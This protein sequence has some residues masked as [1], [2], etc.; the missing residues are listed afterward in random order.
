MNVK[1]F[2]ETA[3]PFCGQVRLGGGDCDC[4]GAKRARKIED[5]IKRAADTIDDLFG[6]S[7]K[8]RGYKPLPEKEIGTLNV[9]AELIANYKMHQ[10]MLSFAGGIRAKLS[11][12]TK[13][14]IKVERSETKKDSAEVKE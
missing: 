2:E 9:L 1:E 14:A 8:E 13:G 5:Q 12:G 11:H 4:D 7:C 6:E 3:C 10:A